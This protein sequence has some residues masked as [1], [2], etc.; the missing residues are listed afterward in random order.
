MTDDLFDDR[1]HG[2]ALAAFVR[3]AREV[4]GPP[5]VDRTRR[6]AYQLY[7]EELARKNAGRGEPADPSD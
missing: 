5:P 1:F 7:E 4:G 2:C 6:L 3:L